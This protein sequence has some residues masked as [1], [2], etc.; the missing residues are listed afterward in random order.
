M[1]TLVKM[2]VKFDTV[3]VEW[4]KQ[5]GLFPGSAVNSVCPI[6]W[7][8]LLLC[9]LLVFLLKVNTAPFLLFIL[10]YIS[11]FQGKICL[12]VLF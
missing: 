4:F 7:I 8:T 5:S 11:F 9:G 3:D 10:F 6:P 12:C 2:K 1:K